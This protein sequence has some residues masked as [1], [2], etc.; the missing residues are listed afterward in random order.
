MRYPES[1]NK[2][3]MVDSVKNRQMIQGDFIKG[4]SIRESFAG[5]FL[6]ADKRNRVAFV[7]A[8]GRQKSCVAFN[9]KEAGG[10]WVCTEKAQETWSTVIINLSLILLTQSYKR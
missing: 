9:D 6:S 10:Q 2:L 3:C 8:S 7:K 1:E 4:N 5:G